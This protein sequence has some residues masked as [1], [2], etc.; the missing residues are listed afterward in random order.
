ML[1]TAGLSLEQAPPI[2]VPFG[3]FLAAPV[4]AIAAGALLV[5]QGDVILASRW[6]P[7]ALAV[8]HLIALGF[9]TQVMAGALL[10]MLPVL[11]GAPVR[12]VTLVG[13]ASQVLLMLGTLAL[14]A[15]LLWGGQP[16]LVLGG[17]SLG[18]GLLLYALVVGI[19]MT[20]A[21]G[22]KPTIL[23]MRLAL[24]A[25]VATLVLGLM[26]VTA[27]LGWL[28]L[29]GLVEWVNLHAAWG[30]LGWVGLL[31]MGVG[32]QVVPMFHVTP[33]YPRWQTRWAAPVTAAALLAATLLTLAG[34][35]DLAGWSAGVGALALGVFALVTLDRQ[36]RRE[37]R[38]VDAT[39][40]YWWSAM[41]SA[42]LAA[43]VWLSGGRAELVGV[44]AL[45]GVGIGL[46]SG[47]LF[48]IVPFLSW[49]HL[50]HRQLATRRFDLRIP[51][52]HAFIPEIQARVQ[53]GL[54]L[55]ALLCLGSAAALPSLAPSLTTGLGTALTQAGGGA[56]VLAATLLGALLA[57]AAVRHRQVRRQFDQASADNPQPRPEMS[58]KMQPSAPRSGNGHQT[59]RP[60][61]RIRHEQRTISA[62]LG[63]YC[64]D[65]HG[66]G[67][68]LCEDCER[69]R[70]YAMARLETCPFQERKPVCNRCQVHCYSRTMRARVRE[71][72][73]HAGPRMPLR[74]PWLAT[75]HLLDKLRQI[76]VLT[77]RKSNG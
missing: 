65:L 2:S 21:R 48:K 71:V 24:A 47:M 68:T 1:N 3:F 32:Y 60:G 69:L 49:F 28:P 77:D 61:P 59:P 67:Q 46:P 16:G 25:L 23:A 42:I 27:L 6:T 73:R 62:M 58:P 74:H 72:M 52:M 64:H 31:I 20:Q 44:L 33:A 10:Q 54:Y 17:A 18:A 9:L 8:T 39:L 41:I 70:Q 50:Q 38:R 22:V 13:R 30:L 37:R 12:R 51:H 34:R 11:A 57:R 63:I 75:R 40:L 45:L 26:L 36:R 53:F 66:G 19:A 15:G 14:S 4:F 29:P 7:A 43:G 56:L 76:P 35:A 5:A 55:L